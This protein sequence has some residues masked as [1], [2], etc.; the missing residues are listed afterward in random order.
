MDPIKDAA[1]DCDC[2]FF[3]DVNRLTIIEFF[4]M[5][6]MK[7]SSELLDELPMILLS[8]SSS[9]LSPMNAFNWF[10]F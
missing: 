8:S 4:P 1:F 6:D 3:V 2:D 10:A 5:S 7:S 9:L